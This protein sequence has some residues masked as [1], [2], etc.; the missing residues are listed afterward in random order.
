MQMLKIRESKKPAMAVSFKYGS[1][2]LSDFFHILINVF[3]CIM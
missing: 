3:D 2:S 1:S